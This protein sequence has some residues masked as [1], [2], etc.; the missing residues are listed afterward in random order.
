[1]NLLPQK[2]MTHLLFTDLYLWQ[3]I[4]AFISATVHLY[5]QWIMKVKIASHTLKVYSR[6]TYT[7]MANL[8]IISEMTVSTAEDLMAV[9]RS[10][11]WNVTI[12]T[13]TSH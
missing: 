12:C 10:I 6:K 9:R 1:M 7:Q 4:I 5:F 13:E 8:Y 3:G 2:K 11:S